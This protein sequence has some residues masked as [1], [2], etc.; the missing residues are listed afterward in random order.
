[1]GKFHWVKLKRFVIFD[2]KKRIIHAPCFNDRVFHHAVMNFIGP[3]L[4]RAMIEYSFA[5]RKGKGVH[6]AAKQV[7]K[8]IRRYSWY[9]KI[10]ILNY[11]ESIDHHLL[12]QMLQRKIKGREVLNITKQIIAGYNTSPEKGLPIG[13]LPSQHF[14][15]YFL[16]K[17]DRYII[18]KLHVNSYV[19]YMDDIIWWCNDKKDSKAILKNV[20]EYIEKNLMLEVKKNVIQ[21]NKSTKGVT[22]CGFRIFPGKI[23]LTPRKQK[24]YTAMRNKWENAYRSGLINKIKLQSA[25][26]SVNAITLHADSIEWKKQ[27]LIRYPSPDY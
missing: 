25:Y 9:V 12:F 10:D 1:M 18:E 2:P 4:D 6:A 26:D 15:N 23:R 22:Y 17:L 14:A 8:N 11:F 21:I 27:Q 13:T 24:R 5:C 19:R 20:I 3:V 16:D 7:Q